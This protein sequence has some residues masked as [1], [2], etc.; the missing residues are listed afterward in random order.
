MEV[1]RGHVEKIT[2]KIAPRSE[3]NSAPDESS[4]AGTASA[5]A[6]QPEAEPEVKINLPQRREVPK[7]GRNVACPCGSGRKYKDCCGKKA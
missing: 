3:Q 5:P 4:I 1:I 6:D 7:V 2:L